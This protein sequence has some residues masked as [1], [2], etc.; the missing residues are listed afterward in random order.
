MAGIAVHRIQR[1]ALARKSLA[2]GPVVCVPWIGDAVRCAG[3]IS[4][5]LRTADR[6]YAVVD[7]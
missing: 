5:A 7:N 1:I 2:T 3:V 6:R 4:D